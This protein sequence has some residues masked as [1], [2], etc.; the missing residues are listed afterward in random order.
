MRLLVG[1]L[2][3]QQGPQVRDGLAA[4]VARDAG[5][6]HDDP[7]VV[8]VTERAE[9]DPL[10]IVAA[11]EPVLRVHVDGLDRARGDQLAELRPPGRSK[12]GT[13]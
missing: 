8:G 4:E 13:L 6:V 5:T 3:G 2:A 7:G 9:G 10:G 11:A 1:L 12:I